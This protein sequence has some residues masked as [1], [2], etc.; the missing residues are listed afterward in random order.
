MPKRAITPTFL[1]GDK[2]RW[3]HSG[4]FTVFGVRANGLVSLEEESGMIS[5]R[6][7]PPDNLFFVGPRHRAPGAAE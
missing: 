7:Y 3:A 2:V 4:P 5:A 1:P 6:F